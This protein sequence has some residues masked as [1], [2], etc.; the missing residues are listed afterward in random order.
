MVDSGASVNVCPKWFGYS[1][2]EQSDDAT[3]LR[4]ANGKPLQEHRKKQIWLKICGQTKAPTWREREES[5][6]TLLWAG[7]LSL[8]VSGRVQTKKSNEVTCIAMTG[9]QYAWK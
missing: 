2:L 9:Q 7:A 1:K 8:L 3:C 4:E 6:A 5:T